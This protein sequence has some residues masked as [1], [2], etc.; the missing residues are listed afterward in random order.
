MA[1]KIEQYD[2]IPI[3]LMHVEAKIPGS[4]MVVLFAF[5]IH[6]VIYHLE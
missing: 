1:I 2:M 4:T 3:S 5:I 6:R